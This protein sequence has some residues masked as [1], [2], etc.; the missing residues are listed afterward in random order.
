VSRST[1]RSPFGGTRPWPCP[2]QSRQAPP[3]PASRGSFLSFGV[4]TALHAS[5]P[6]C[7]RRGPQARALPLEAKRRWRRGCGRARRGGRPR[8]TSARAPRGSCPCWTSAGRWGW[9]VSGPSRPPA[10]RAPGATCGGGG[11]PLPWPRPCWSGPWPWRRPRGAAG[12]G[13]GVRSWPPP[14]GAVRAG[15]RPPC[16]GVA[17]RGAR[18]GASRPRHWAHPPRRAWRTPAGRWWHTAVSQPP[19]P[20]LGGSPGPGPA[21]WAWGGRR[22]HGGPAGWRR[23]RRGRPRPRRCRRAGRPARR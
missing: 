18:P 20:S 3:A 22:W 2:Q 21:P 23:R 9:T 5:P 10:A 4:S 15:G 17:R 6:T 16:P 8:V 12:R 11:S 1:L 19:G 7:R 13:T 14:R